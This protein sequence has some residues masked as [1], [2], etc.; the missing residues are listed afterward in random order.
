[1]SVEDIGRRAEVLTAQLNAQQGAVDAPMAAVFDAL[2]L[3]IRPGMMVVDT[4]T[5][6]TVEVVSGG[7]EQ[8]SA[9]ATGA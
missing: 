1:M 2:G 9:S 4:V 5:G 7:I 6:E 8:I 3:R